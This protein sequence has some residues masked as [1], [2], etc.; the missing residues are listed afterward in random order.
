MVFKSRRTLQL[1]SMRKRL[2]SRL[3]ANSSDAV[4]TDMLADVPVLPQD[5]GELTD[6]DDDD[7]TPATMA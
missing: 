3:E 2:R 4:N 5:D 7:R 1:E 6:T